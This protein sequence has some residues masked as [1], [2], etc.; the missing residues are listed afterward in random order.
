VTPVAP[1]SHDKRG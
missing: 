1:V